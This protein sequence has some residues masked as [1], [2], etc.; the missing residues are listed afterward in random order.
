MHK[1]YNEDV[2]FTFQSIMDDLASENLRNLTGHGLLEPHDGN[3]IGSL[4]FLS[5]LIM[6]LSL[7]STKALSIR[8]NLTN[9]ETNKTEP[10][11]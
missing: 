10:I 5:I 11:S 7:Y 4:Y 3:G 8:M 2:I 1:L 9:R 6:L